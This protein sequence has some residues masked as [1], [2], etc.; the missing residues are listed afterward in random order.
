MGDAY[1]AVGVL[2]GSRGEGV[3]LILC[4]DVRGDAFVAVGMIALVVTVLPRCIGKGS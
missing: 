2:I 1:S 3:A 4:E